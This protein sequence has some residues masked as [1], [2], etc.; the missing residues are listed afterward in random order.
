MFFKDGLDFGKAV[1]PFEDGF[2]AFIVLKTK[3]ELLTDGVRETSDFAGASFHNFD[4]LV[5]RVA[6][7]VRHPTSDRIST[8]A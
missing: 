2:A 3:V 7:G 5:L 1:E 6:G 4:F 8:D